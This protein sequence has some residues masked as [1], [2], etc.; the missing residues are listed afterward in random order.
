MTEA[1]SL[2]RR[3][4]EEKIVALAWKD[5]AFRER[6][7]ANPKAE[8]E[9]RLGVKLPPGLQMAAYQED[10]SNLHFVIPAKPSVNISE[11]SDADLEKVAGGV[12][13]IASAVAT[14]VISLI[15]GGA[16]VGT[17][18]GGKAIGEESKKW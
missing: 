13:V 8:F 16:G 7:L 12:D 11:L 17:Y 14:A 2:T 1:A 10:G 9:S 3:D 15:A 6:F 4:I 18:F 5:D